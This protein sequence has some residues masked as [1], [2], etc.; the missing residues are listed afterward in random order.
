MAE[1]VYWVLEVTVKPQRLD[2][3]KAHMSGS[4]DT[5]VKDA[6]VGLNPV[7][8]SSLRGFQR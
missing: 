8:M 5:Q 7:Y 3:L 4:P 6:L 1:T 2:D